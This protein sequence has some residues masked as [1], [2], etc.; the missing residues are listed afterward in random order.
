[1]RSL[2]LVTLVL[3]AIAARADFVSSFDG[4]IVGQLADGTPYSQTGYCGNFVESASTSC[5]G[6]AGDGQVSLVL[7]AAGS[8]SDS[9]P[10]LHATASGTVTYT[11]IIT[12]YGQGPGDGD[13]VAWDITSQIGDGAIVDVNLPWAIMFNVP[14]AMSI[15][16]SDAVGANSGEDE[17][18]AI[19]SI[20]INGFQVFGPDCFTVFGGL[21]GT[22][23]DP[24][25]CG[26]AI[27]V[28]V[29][30]QSG[31]LYGGQPVGGFAADGP[32]P[33]PASLWLLATAAGIALLL[34]RSGRIAH[35]FRLWLTFR[36]TGSAP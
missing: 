24:A 23:Y 5:S 3:L 9:G 10:Q 21:S 30:T 18:T 32:V 15:S 1:M 17:Y 13:Q 31:F 35:N 25:Q 16:I 2:Q 8:G 19:D 12:F 20:A 33:E 34:S 7:V 28:M 22:S 36:A 6:T 4:S 11:D 26:A 14:Y 27:P 29:D